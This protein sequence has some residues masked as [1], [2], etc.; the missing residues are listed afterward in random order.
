[1]QVPRF[2]KPHRGLLFMA[3]GIIL[4]L[5]VTNIITVGLQL[6]LLLAALVL[7][8]YGFLEF[9]GYNK[10]MRLFKRKQH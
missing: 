5:Y 4:F 2:D 1:M 7:I 3:A 9:D 6:V 8:G 10:L